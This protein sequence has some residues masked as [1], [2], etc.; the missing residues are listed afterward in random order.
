MKPISGMK[1]RI[2]ALR[3]KLGMTQHDLAKGIGKARSTIA[4]YESGAS[5]MPQPILW[6]MAKC[7]HSR[8]D[9]LYELD[10]EALSPNGQEHGHA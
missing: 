3:K 7:L 6:K 1:P 4:G 5:G 8:V 10:D 2:K 9:E